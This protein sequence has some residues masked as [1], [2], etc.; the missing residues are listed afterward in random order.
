[1]KRI[2]VDWELHVRGLRQE[3]GGAV[4]NVLICFSHQ[5]VYVCVPIVSGLYSLAA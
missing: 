4:K 1:M 3:K 5:Q 2:L